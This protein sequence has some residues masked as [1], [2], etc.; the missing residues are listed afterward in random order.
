MYLPEAFQETDLEALHAFIREHSFG[1][2]VSG[3]SRSL[4]ASHLPFLLEADGGS[5][6]SL[7]GH[8]ARANTQWEE[9]AEGGEVLVI[10]GGPHAY[11]SPSFYETELSV[12]TWNYTVVHA[13][14]IPRLIEGEELYS[15]LEAS[16]RYYEEGRA[17]PWEFTRLPPDFIRKMMRGIVGFEI[18]IQRLEGKS[19]LSQNRSLADRRGVIGGLSESGRPEEREIATRMRETLEAGITFPS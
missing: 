15:L 10:F 7:K 8:L 17:D 6:G 13:Y 2:L 5:Y 11:V 9:F 12:P 19:K 18:P 1:T 3:G 4:Q 14:G 16:V